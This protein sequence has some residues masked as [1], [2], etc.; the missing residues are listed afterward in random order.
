MTEQTKQLVLHTLNEI[1]DE[2]ATRDETR[3]LMAMIMAISAL[4]SAP[5][6][7]PCSEEMPKS[8]GFYMVTIRTDNVLQHGE[9]ESRVEFD[10]GDWCGMSS[11]MKVIAWR[12]ESPYS[13][14]KKAQEA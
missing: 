6:W 5:V 9:Y 2:V 1:K 12:E 13:P 4:E 14:D 11:D 8:D 10:R 3:Y 7:T